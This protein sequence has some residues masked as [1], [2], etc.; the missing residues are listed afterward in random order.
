ML[1]VFMEKASI[2]AFQMILKFYG[3]SGFAGF[4]RIPSQSQEKGK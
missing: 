2:G 1:H 3:A 4:S